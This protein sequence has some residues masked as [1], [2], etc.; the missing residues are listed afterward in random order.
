M[1]CTLVLHSRHTRPRRQRSLRNPL[2]MLPSRRNQH[3]HK[4][5]GLA[6]E[7]EGYMRLTT[8]VCPGQAVKKSKRV[9][10]DLRGM[11]NLA[12][13]IRAE[14]FERRNQLYARLPLCFLLVGSFFAITRLVQLNGRWC[15][16]RLTPAMRTHTHTHTHA[17]TYMQDLN[18]PLPHLKGNTHKYHVD[19]GG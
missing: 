8:V 3:R 6:E 11:E 13:K 15:A 2:S 9:C 18:S 16:L 14:E 4:R 7:E 19:D 17:H 1:P 12:W 10:L 5:R